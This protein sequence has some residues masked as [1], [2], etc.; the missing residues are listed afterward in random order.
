M[1]PI[2][3]GRRTLV[4][5][6]SRQVGMFRIKEIDMKALTLRHLVFFA[7][8]ASLCL[9]LPEDS[10]AQLPRI[11]VPRPAP[12]KTQP[13]PAETTANKEAGASVVP[14]SDQAHKT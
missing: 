12:T 4:G 11:R 10:A 3:R 13:T 8:V 7:A 5:P 6:K 2:R 14:A 1:N 9:V